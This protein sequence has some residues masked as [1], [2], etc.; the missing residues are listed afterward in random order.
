LL[1]HL[2][3]GRFK[4]IGL[5][6]GGNTL[7]HMATQQPGRV[8]AMVLVSA[9]SYYPEQARTL[10][11][12]FTIESRTDED[13]QFMRQSHKYGDEQIRALWMHGQALKDSYDDMNFTAPTCQRSLPE[14]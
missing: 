3:I 10:M 8:E 13:W 2:D 14:R 12:Q 4:A 7:L 9:T 5:S 1:D 11:R 6:G